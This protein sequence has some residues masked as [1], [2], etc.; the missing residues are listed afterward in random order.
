MS[1]SQRRGCKEPLRFAIIAK[2][3]SRIS[4]ADNGI[5]IAPEDH[6]RIFE[7]FVQVGSTAKRR[8]NGTGLGLALVRE[9]ANIQ[10]FSVSVQSA[11]DEGSTFIITIPA[12][13]IV[14]ES[15]E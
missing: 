14:R 11:L 1:C 15:D 6:E 7:R 13:S 3:P 5:G 2:N 8:Y 4:V 12:D 9:Y 10:G